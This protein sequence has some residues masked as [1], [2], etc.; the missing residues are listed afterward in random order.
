MSSGESSSSSTVQT[1]NTQETISL[2][3]SGGDGPTIA[4]SAGN[5]TYTSDGGAVSL[6]ALEGMATVVEKALET[7]AKTVD[8]QADT[9]AAASQTNSQTLS[10]VLKANLTLAENKQTGTDTGTLR[11]VIYAAAGLAAL[12]IGFFFFRP[13]TS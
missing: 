11:T 13:K 9:Y 2:Q 7:G 1:T 5:I 10:E 6:K 4:S 3:G 8:H 12:L